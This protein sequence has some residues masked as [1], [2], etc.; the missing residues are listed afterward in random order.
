MKLKWNL[1]NSWRENDVKELIEQNFSPIDGLTGSGEDSWE[2][3]KERL[4]DILIMILA[5]WKYH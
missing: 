2:K 3:V 4:L 5:T 1:E